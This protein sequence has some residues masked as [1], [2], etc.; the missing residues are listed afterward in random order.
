MIDWERIDELKEEVG[1]D[2]FVEIAS[3]F[4]E[5]VEEIL[6][7]LSTIQNPA[8]LSDNFH[9]LKGSALNLGFSEMA[10]LCALAEADADPSHASD[11][12]AIFESSRD[13]LRQR[14]PKL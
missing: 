7:S 4:L 12:I 10:R 3:L 14:Y 8:A 5:E 6:A 9:S 1:L 13:G 2:D 11:I